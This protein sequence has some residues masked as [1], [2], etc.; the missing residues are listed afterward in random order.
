M[1]RRNDS[2][3][4]IWRMR[5]QLGRIWFALAIGMIGLGAFTVLYA[6]VV[7]PIE[8]ITVG[9]G[10]LVGGAL[11]AVGFRRKPQRK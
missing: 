8:T 6:L 4:W 3:P 7:G 1:A 2:S 11:L 10:L 9:L 5:H